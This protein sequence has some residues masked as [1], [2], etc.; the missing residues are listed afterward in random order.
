MLLSQKWGRNLPHFQKYNTAGALKYAKD[1][2]SPKSRATT[3]EL[4]PLSLDALRP[5]G[6]PLE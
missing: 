6:G 3:V 1:L 4:V 5:L 2:G